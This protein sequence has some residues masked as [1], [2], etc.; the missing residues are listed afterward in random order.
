PTSAKAPATRRRYGTSFTAL[1]RSGVLKAEATVADLGTVDWRA[2]ETAWERG[3]ADWNHLR[4]AI[5][6]FLTLHLG[7]VYHPLRRAVVKAI[8]KRREQSRVPDLSPTL[9]WNIVDAAPEYVKAAYVTI[10]A[11]GLRVGEYL[12]LTKEHLLPH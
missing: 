12:A 4:R 6:H 3:A 1:E 7:D 9:F 11:L 5:S 10:A 2:L 8:P